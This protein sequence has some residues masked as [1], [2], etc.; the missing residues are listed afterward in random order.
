MWLS[1]LFNFIGGGDLVFY[2]LIQASI[3]ESVEQSSL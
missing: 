2:S 3:A 1:G